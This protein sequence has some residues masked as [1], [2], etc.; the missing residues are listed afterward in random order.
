MERCFIQVTRYLLIRDIARRHLH[1]LARQGEP[2]NS[3]SFDSMLKKSSRLNRRHGS[4][5]DIHTHSQYLHGQP[6]D[7]LLK[8][9][10]SSVLKNSKALLFN[11]FKHSLPQSKCDIMCCIFKSQRASLHSGTS[12]PQSNCDIMRY[13][14]KFQRASL[15]SGTSLN[16]DRISTLGYIQP[17]P[18][19][20]S[21]SDS[22][23]EDG[24][25][26]PALEAVT[27]NVE[28]P[29]RVSIVPGK[30]PPSEPPV[31]CCMSGCANCVWIQYCEELKHYFSDGMGQEIAKEA[32]ENIENPGLKM[33]LKVELGFI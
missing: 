28:P 3:K 4:C 24:I 5:S 22:D 12:L 25:L 10:N 27:P 8:V 6:S 29:H 32:I 7:R 23:R 33:F 21:D 26:R 18:T 14:F 2:K 13:I 31:D 30:G 16:T 20:S 17:D 1:R 15:H 9:C 11:K 19:E